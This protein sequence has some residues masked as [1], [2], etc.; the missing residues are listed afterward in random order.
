MRYYDPPRTAAEGTIFPNSA[1]NA[2]GFQWFQGGIMWGA[3]F[4]YFK[5]VGDQ[6]YVET[7]TQALVLASFGR[8]ASFLGFFSLI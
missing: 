3:M 5:T 7:V 8:T 6:T 2:S 1:R 4:E